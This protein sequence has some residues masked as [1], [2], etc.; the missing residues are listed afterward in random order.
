MKCG[1][2]TFLGLGSSTGLVQGNPKFRVTGISEL[3][4]KL[5]STRKKKMSTKCESSRLW[6]HIPEL[7][8]A[9]AARLM[10]RS[11]VFTHT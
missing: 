1:L 3:L 6:S 8:W 5:I 4:A 11:R 2:Q 9:R 7:A 10:P